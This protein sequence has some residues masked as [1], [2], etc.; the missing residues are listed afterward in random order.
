MRICDD[1]YR[2]WSGWA[3]Y[4]DRPSMT[5]WVTLPL[6]R[7]GSG[8]NESWAWER[9]FEMRRIHRREHRELCT[10]QMRSAVENCRRAHQCEVAA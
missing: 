7:P 4:R 3:D 2:V 10:A 6:C 8:T 9:S 1:C 5:R